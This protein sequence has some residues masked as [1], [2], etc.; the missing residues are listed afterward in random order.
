MNQPGANQDL[1]ANI[2][3]GKVALKY[4]TFGKSAVF[5]ILQNENGIPETC[6][7]SFIS[8]HHILTAAHC[9]TSNTE[10]TTLSVGVNPIEEESEMMLTIEKITV[11]PDYSKTNNLNRNDL[12]IIKFKETYQY[13]SFIFKLPLYSEPLL[14]FNSYIKMVTAVGYGQTSAVEGDENQGDSI[15][16][17]RYVKLD[18]D[19][20]MDK[21]IIVNQSTGGGVC[22]GDSGGSITLKYNRDKYIVGVASGVFSDNS[23][24]ANITKGPIDYCRNK[25]IF[26]NVMYYLP[27]IQ[28]T[29][30]L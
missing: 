13:K 8:P 25:S 28:A 15:G 3:D 10:D 26:M 24:K 29:M 19:L 7:G 1:A 20:S 17:L 5:I 27:W 22:F 6:S 11:H 2:V 9:V 18:V 30:A 23:D 21:N 4:N 12:A 14:Q 16:V